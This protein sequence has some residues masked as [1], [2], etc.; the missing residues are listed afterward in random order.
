MS[1]SLDAR[2]KRVFDQVIDCSGAERTL[3]LDRTCAGA[4]ELRERVEVLLAAAQKDD[5]FLADPTLN[6]SR[7]VAR[8]TGEQPG[9][10]IG[11]YVL[12]ELIGEG[13]F[14]SVF[15]AEQSAP[16]RRQV[17]LKI[18][19]AGMDTKQV[20]ARFD[21][22]RQALAM[23]DHPNIARV[24]E[25]GATD[26]GR[27][28]FVMEF[29]RG[30]PLTH[31]CDR[32]RLS[33]KQRLE[34]LCDVC[35]A[36]Q[37]AHQKGIIH[38]DLKPSNILVT[39]VDGVPLAKVIDFGIAKATEA[40]PADPTLTG[41]HQ[42][43]GTPEYMS[44]EQMEPGGVDVDTRSDIYS[45]GVLL[46]ELL[47]GMTPFDRRLINDRGRDRT[48]APLREREP[49]RPSVRLQTLAAS[50]ARVRLRSEAS[51]AEPAGAGSSVIEIA[52]RRQTEPA[53]LVRT[54][55][56]DLDWVVLKCLDK[57]RAR[58]YPTAGA[59]AEDIRRFLDHQPVLATPPS[60]G[61]KLRKFAR[62]HRTGV[63]AASG[64]AA[65]LVL[66]M[67]GTSVGLVWA[68]N[69]QRRT[70]QQKV[71]AQSE[72]RRANDA[73]DEAR[74]AN[75]FMREVLTSV[76]PDKDGAD[77]RLITVLA[78]ASSAAAQRFANRPLQEF[79]VRDLLAQVYNH[80]SLW[81]EAKREY[82]TA[83]AL[84]RSRAGPDDP[85]ALL[86]ELNCAGMAL[87]LSQTQ[88]AETILAGLI[89]R[90]ERV[91]GPDHS[92][93]LSAQ[94]SRAIA[95]KRWGRLGE[96]ED[97][98][99]GLRAHP[100]L[101]ADDE[102]Q[103]RIVQTLADIARARRC[104]LGTRAARLAQAAQ[105]ELLA[106]EWVERATRLIGPAARQ[107]LQGQVTLAGALCAQGRCRE[108]VD[109]CHAVLESTAD[110][111]PA[112]HDV[113][114]FAM[115]TLAQ[116]SAHL[117]QADEAAELCRLR[118]QCR[119]QEGRP[120]DPVL[121]AAIHDSLPYFDRAGWNVEGEARAR[122]LAAAMQHFGAT[123]GNLDFTSGVYIANFASIQARAAEAEA[124][125]GSLLEREEQA[126]T[127][128]AARL[129][130][131]YGLHLVR[132]GL[133]D[134]AERQLVATADLIED[135]RVG[136][137]WESHPDD[138]ILGFITLYDAWDKPDQAEGYRR[139]R[140]EIM[141]AVPQGTNGEP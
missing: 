114:S 88:E 22:E 44:P 36:V 129:H 24:L 67:A 66:G 56:R 29:V 97:I 91:L 54:L 131:L 64:V 119:R 84:C 92:K 31:Y 128:D 96:A 98:L 140:D 76:D 48:G 8:A 111:M 19:K 124:I 116:A 7:A 118:I 136:T 109:L 42:L 65:A 25:A 77:V 49:S 14:G 95:L 60:A 133:F 126:V 123:H 101:I 93:T 121:L 32:E 73:A 102:M 137:G 139:L 45:L 99:R 39:T 108:A 33:V 51:P 40:R 74:A 100:A 113:R 107:T 72:A 141:S 58:R 13:G 62:R 37:H 57:D 78:Q 6:L 132:Q 90:L 23:M 59:L 71:V 63:L 70:E 135:I 80:L 10:Q 52:R 35:A 9:T 110:R 115:D 26:G 17:A 85:R 79:A 34:L 12:L 105:E 15:L 125:F 69:E 38:R 68:L 21:V 16:V 106:R 130:L 2:A 4:P 5:T 82:Q 1:E 94:R 61:Y 86:A 20:I 83:L 27:P 138:V 104:D 50:S 28:Y 103:M 55:R 89:P 75:E 120:S 117:G 127:G 53:V 41:V 134:E 122:E 112:C 43:I 46:Y 87:N 18:I 3:L 11:P 30:E 81:S 47:T